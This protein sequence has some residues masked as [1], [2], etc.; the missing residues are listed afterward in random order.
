[1][2]EEERKREKRRKIRVMFPDGTVVCYT[3]VKQT[4]METLKKIGPERLSRVDFEVCHLPLFSQHVYSLYADFM[5]PIGGGWY[6]NAIGDTRM[7]YAQLVSI[8]KQLGLGLTIDWSE[9][10]VGAKTAR[11]AKP[12]TVLEVTFA[13]GT[14]IGEE[15]TLDTFVQCV[16]HLG[17]DNVRKLNLK[18]G[19]KDLITLRKTYRGQV[20]V[21][22][23]RWLLVP[24]VVK[25][26]VKLLR[27][28]G[29]MLHVDWKIDYF[30]TAENKSYRR[31]GDKRSH[32]KELEQLQQQ[33][34]AARA[35][36]HNDDDDA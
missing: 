33:A 6:V 35:P 5:E 18:H 26:R 25:D 24:P 32:S 14:V 27:V 34:Q 29:A 13:D 2:A 3:S 11:G 22:Q 1:M 36:H 23:D 12:Q 8:N 30:T 9:D 19:A 28:I 20:Q 16:G 31:I 10:L 17:I 4:Y 15:N 21:D 7:R